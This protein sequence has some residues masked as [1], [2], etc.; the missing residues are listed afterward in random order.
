MLSPE[1]ET[2][3]I[4]SRCSG[5]CLPCPFAQSNIPQRFLPAEEVVRKIRNSRAQLV[6]VTG[7][8]PL[9]HPQFSEIIERV[10]ESHANASQ[11]RFRIAT[12]GHIPLIR[13]WIDN[14]MRS[15]GFSGFSVG[16]DVLS[17]TCRNRIPHTKVWRENIALLN[18]MR[19]RYSL[20]V[21]VHDLGESQFV[22]NEDRNNATF[23]Q[24]GKYL[25][26]ALRLGA[27]PEF[28]YLR[29]PVQS[30]SQQ[31]VTDQIK[32]HFENIPFVVERI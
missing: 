31:T 23:L 10:R 30:A 6:V 20:T 3:L 16:T 29:L 12:G 4:T 9:E 19:T 2:L 27:K 28:V 18:D 15:P 1:V 5:G 14:L 8:E 24:V 22:S 11:S 32:I 7:G 13:N 25:S 17:D 21:T 26:V